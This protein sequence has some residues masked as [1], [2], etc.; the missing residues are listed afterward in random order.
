MEDQMIYIGGG[1]QKKQKKNFFIVSFLSLWQK[2]T[3]DQPI[4]IGT[5]FV[6]SF[7]Y[8]YSFIKSLRGAE[9]STAEK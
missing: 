6:L 8:G 9:I 2:I 4:L 5:A 1:Q 7:S 3:E